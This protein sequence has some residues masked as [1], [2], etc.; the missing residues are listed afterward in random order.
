MA[1]GATARAPKVQG[2][3]ADDVEMLVARDG[4]LT[5]VNGVR[6]TVRKGSIIAAN[7][8]IVKG[9]AHFFVKATESTTRAARRRR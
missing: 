7:D 6:R 9:R 8:P 4:F 1:N 2:Q 3:K 5:E